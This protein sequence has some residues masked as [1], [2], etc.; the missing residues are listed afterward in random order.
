M[1]NNSTEVPFYKLKGLSQDALTICTEYCNYRILICG[2]DP[3][4]T[5]Y[6]FLK[7]AVK[8]INKILAFQEFLLRGGKR[9][10]RH[11]TISKKNFIFLLN[12]EVINLMYVEECAV[13]IEEFPF[14]DEALAYYRVC[15]FPHSFS[16]CFHLLKRGDNL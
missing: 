9:Q 8:F 13:S 15:L 12:Q 3:K 6:R 7:S 1:S 14:L 4:L 16:R 2:D 11:K 10:K 5:T